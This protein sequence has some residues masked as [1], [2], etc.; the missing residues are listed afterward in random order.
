MGEIVSRIADA[1]KRAHADMQPVR[2]RVGRGRAELAHNRRVVDENGKSRM[3]FDYDPEVTTGPF[4]PDLP[5]IRLDAPEGEPLAIAYNFAAHALTAGPSNRLYT[6]D[7]PGVA[8]ARIQARHPGCTPLFLNGGAGNQHPRK[9]M[10]EGFAAAEEIGDALA[11]HVLEAAAGAEP[12]EAASLAFASDRMA[13]PHRL[14]A[15]RTVEVE[16]SSFR[17]GPVV[18]GVMPGEPFVEFQLAFKR[19]VAPG[20]GMFIGY[21]NG[22][23]GY[24]P[25]RSAYEEGGYG[26]AAYHGDPPE[27]SRTGLPPKAGEAMLQRLVDMA[28]TLSV[29]EGGR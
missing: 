11:K 29:E 12:A 16:L 1:V 17:L 10:R 7:F 23:R 4:D 13:F 22:G 6:A 2:L 27:R 18:A 15:E 24:V 20:V 19:A 5:V 26:V 3:V 28:E 8:N 14:Y 25:T 21:A 9:S